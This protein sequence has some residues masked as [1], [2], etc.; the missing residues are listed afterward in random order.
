MK[1]TIALL[2]KYESELAKLLN[3]DPPDFEDMWHTMTDEAIEAMGEE[4]VAIEKEKM[5]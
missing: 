5:L 2:R 4:Y 3:E 1:H